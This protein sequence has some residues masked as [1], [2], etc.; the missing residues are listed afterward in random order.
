MTGGIPPELGR[1][2]RLLFLGLGNNALTGTIPSSLG[3]LRRL[4]QLDLPNLVL[5]GPIP[6]VF[7]ELRALKSLVV[8]NTSL[9]GRL[10]QQLTAVQLTQFRWA[11]TGLCAPANDAF[12]AWLRSITINVGGAACAQ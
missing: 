9:S 5:T 2:T 3:D 8:T 11:G 1:L 4:A 12:Q 7:G 10:P 6:S